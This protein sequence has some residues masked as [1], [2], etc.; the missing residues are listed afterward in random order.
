MKKYHV[1]SLIII[2]ISISLYA[3]DNRKQDLNDLAEKFKDSL[4]Y[5]G[6][7][8]VADDTS[9]LLEKAYGYAN[10]E[11][12]VKNKIDT[13]FRIASISKM[14]VSYAIFIL[15]DNKEI[16]FNES[17]E[18]YFPLLKRELSEKITIKH[19]LSHSSGL[20]RDI[21][22]ISSK[23]FHENYT[24]EEF[25]TILNSTNLQSTPGKRSSYSNVGFSLLGRIIE[26]VTKKNFNEA[27]S[28]LIFKP[29]K[30]KNTGHEIEGHIITDLANGY[31]AIGE[32]LFKSSHENKSHV[33]AA[34][35]MYSSA[36]DLLLFA[37][38]VLRG[39]LIS[40]ETRK[41]YLKTKGYSTFSG[42]V[43]WNYSSNLNNQTSSGQ[44]LMHGGSCPG[45]RATI[46][47]FL[48][49]K[50]VVIGLSNKAPIN[51]SLIYNKLGNI[52][53]GLEPEELF[54]PNLSKL[55]TNILDGKFESTIEKYDKLLKSNPNNEKLKIDELNTMGY[56]YLEY[57]K[58]KE[59][60]NF[61]KFATM[62]FPKNS[63]AFDSL[64]EALIRDGKES[65]AIKMYEK[66]LKLNP[67][68]E[69]A[70]AVIRQYNNN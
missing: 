15:A 12:S 14:F 6:V 59:A 57:N 13:K 36:H 35:S 19:L 65:E 41:L 64:G 53:V 67:K 17:I 4:D 9:V 26:K 1:L 31:N 34:G 46:G 70:K 63:N 2:M 23:S 7:F 18:K 10:M 42:W 20:I 60:I 3:Q 8:L 49:A 47:I 29:L 28:Q 27:M 48:E 22:N 68:N 62:L 16:D 25:I 66:S 52:A 40:N 58:T 38:E 45:Y 30:L 33:F 55:T 5:S 54:K 69:N 43:T 50:T 61:F 37:K 32:E 11:H 51:T 39:S 24:E 21:D 56:L 44:F